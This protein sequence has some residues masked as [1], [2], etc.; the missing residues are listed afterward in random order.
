MKRYM[1]RKFIGIAFCVLLLTASAVAQKLR[2]YQNESAAF[3]RQDKLHYPPA[4]GIVFT[5][6][7]SI[8]LWEGLG[9][10]FPGKE[11]INR[12]FGGSTLPEL[13]R[14]LETLVLQYQP[15]QVVIYSGDNDIAKGD[16]AGEVL[17][18]FKRVFMKLRQQLP[19]V[20]VT[21]IS[22]K[23]SPARANKLEEMRKANELIQA[24]LQQQQHASYVDVFTPM[25]DA[26]GKP[27][28]EL[29]GKDL[30]HMNSKGYALWQKALA[31]TLK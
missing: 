25:L 3:A 21:Y 30:L 20:T 13:E 23:P 1:R 28:A 19:E 5:G 27:R 31:P 4:Q 26:A 7:S 12:G 16:S 22:I 17:A 18:S 6:S 14:Y 9:K 10:A 2:S 11:I 15:R 24:Y 29:F 8:R